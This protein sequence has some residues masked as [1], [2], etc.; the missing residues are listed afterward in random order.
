MERETIFISQAFSVVLLSIVF[1]FY[2]SMIQE[3]SMIIKS[4]SFFVSILLFFAIRSLLLPYRSCSVVL[5]MFFREEDIQEHIMLLFELNGYRLG[6]IK[7]LI[8]VFK[9]NGF[10]VQG[11]SCLSFR[12]MQLDFGFINNSKYVNFMVFLS[13]KM[14]FFLPFS[15]FLRLLF[16]K[17]N[18]P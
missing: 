17:E 14:S 10:S 18:Y 8:A 16:L 9:D 2:C 13:L 5:F 12:S 1:C 3:S 6:F 4:I 11:L 7:Y 15:L